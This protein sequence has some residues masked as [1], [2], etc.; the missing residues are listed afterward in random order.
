MTGM[1]VFLEAACPEWNETL[2]RSFVDGEQLMSFQAALGFVR[3]DLKT[4]QCS[5]A[6]HEYGFPGRKWACVLRHA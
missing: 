2:R 6:S 5:P 4:L 3:S 1:A